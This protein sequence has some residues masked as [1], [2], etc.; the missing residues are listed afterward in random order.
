MNVNYG[1]LEALKKLGNGKKN[2][3]TTEQLLDENLKNIAGESNL[4][5]RK[6]M[7]EC[8]NEI[9]FNNHGKRIAIFS[10]SAAIKF[11]LQHFC[12]FNYEDNNFVF[13]NQV[14]CNARFES[15]SVLKFIFEDETLVS[16]DKIELPKNR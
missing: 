16:I 2:D 10:H 14:V 12:E 9:L 5:V 7:L 1:D 6:I 8:I 11:F 15:P 4:E 3:F 13:Q